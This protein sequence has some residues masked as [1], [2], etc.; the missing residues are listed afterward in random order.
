MLF[1]HKYIIYVYLHIILPLVNQY[2]FKAIRIL[3]KPYGSQ[4]VAFSVGILVK[5]LANV[6]RLLNIILKLLTVSC[7]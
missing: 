2:S 1:Y 6:F 4:Q 3:L 5:R 7:N